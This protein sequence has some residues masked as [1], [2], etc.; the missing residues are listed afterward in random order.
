[1]RRLAATITC[2]TLAMSGC[3][4][5]PPDDYLPLGDVTDPSSATSVEVVSPKEGAEVGSTFTV[6][7]KIDG[8]LS[9]PDQVV[10]PVGLPH[11]H[12]R[13]DDGTFD[14]GHAELDPVVRRREEPAGYSPSVDTK[15][16]YEDIPP[17]EHVLL[18][19]LVRDD[20]DPAAEIDGSS[21]TF[22]VGG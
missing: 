3:G 8:K 20:H 2:L 21:V 6:K 18:V 5:A 10:T 15:L 4:G 19:D 7:V 11:L 1:M 17:G 16:T 12:F 14:P 13:L 22:T 9:R